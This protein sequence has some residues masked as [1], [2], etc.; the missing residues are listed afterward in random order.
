M[1]TA[2]P[3]PKWHT[4]DERSGWVGQWFRGW[5]YPDLRHAASGFP[6]ADARNPDGPSRAGR[7]GQRLGTE[8]RLGP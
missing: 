7:L 4:T 5:K 2:A 3:G 1:L 6:A 8:W